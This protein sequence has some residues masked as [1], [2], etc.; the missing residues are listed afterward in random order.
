MN[1]PDTHCQPWSW[2]LCDVFQDVPLPLLSRSGKEQN[3]AKCPLYLDNARRDGI[4]Q[5]LYC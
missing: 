4:P 1:L 2:G 3:R 5:G